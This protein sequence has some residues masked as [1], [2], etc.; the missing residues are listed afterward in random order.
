LVFG[1]KR[2]NLGVP[3]K[4]LRVYQTEPSLGCGITA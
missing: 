2:R 1:S 4:M 3:T